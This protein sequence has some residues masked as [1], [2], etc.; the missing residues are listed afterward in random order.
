MAP[1]AH[2]MLDDLANNHVQH[3]TILMGSDSAAGR[4]SR[5]SHVKYKVGYRGAYKSFKG[6]PNHAQDF[7]N[8]Q[9][10]KALQDVLRRP[11]ENQSAHHIAETTAAAQRAARSDQDRAP[12]HAAF[13][14]G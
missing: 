13:H 2:P 8:K 5:M 1:S 6:P 14:P 10:F 12:Y 9:N 3:S 7:A 4:T 11:P